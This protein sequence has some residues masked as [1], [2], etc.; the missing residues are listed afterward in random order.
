MKKNHCR[1]PKLSED[2]F[3]F[4]NIFTYMK[5]RAQRNDNLGAL[6][7]EWVMIKFW[8]NDQIQ[9]NK[10]AE[11]IPIHCYEFVFITVYSL[12]NWSYLWLQKFS[13]SVH[14]NYE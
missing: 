1:W 5:D 14:Y 13:S 8:L 3:P 12:L 10:S 4:C 6:L 11:M 7:D 2:N 9:T